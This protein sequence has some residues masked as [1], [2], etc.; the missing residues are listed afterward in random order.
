MSSH[1]NSLTIDLQLEE[2]IEGHVE[3]AASSVDSGQRNLQSAERSAV[4]IISALTYTYKYPL[5]TQSKTCPG[6]CFYS[7]HIKELSYCLHRAA[8]GRRASSC[9]R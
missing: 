2:S 9:G 1:P 4:R 8:T 7:D 6:D 3:Q 5:I